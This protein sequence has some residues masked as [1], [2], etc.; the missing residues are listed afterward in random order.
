MNDDD[1]IDDI[2]F[3]KYINYAKSNVFPELDDE[4]K[5]YLED[6]Y[7]NVRKEAFENTDSKPITMRDLMSIKRLTI[8][9]A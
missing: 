6:V 3:K 9:R 7:V 4:A 8:A 1:L 2:L 5:K